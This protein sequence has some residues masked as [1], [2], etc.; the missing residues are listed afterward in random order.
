M[1]ISD[2]LLVDPPVTRK[3]L[4]SSLYYLWRYE[5]EFLSLCFNSSSSV[6]CLAKLQGH[7]KL[8]CPVLCYRP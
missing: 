8:A 4:S 2:E 7:A 1:L 6:F 5:Y 3:F